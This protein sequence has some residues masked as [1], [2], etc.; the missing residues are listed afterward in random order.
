MIT[1]FWVVFFG[2]GLG[3]S[4]HAYVREGGGFNLICASLM[5]QCLGFIVIEAW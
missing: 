1:L 5:F 4:G 3:Y 2:L